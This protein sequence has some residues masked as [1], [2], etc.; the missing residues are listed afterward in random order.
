MESKILQRMLSITIGC[1]LLLSLLP[2]ANKINN[3]ASAASTRLGLHV[4]QEEIEIWRER[5]EIGPYREINDAGRN[6]RGEWLRI[7]NNAQ[8]FLNNPSAERWIPKILEGTTCPTPENMG[9]NPDRR[10]GDKIRDA[11]F[12]YLLFGG[13]KYLTAVRNELIAQVSEPTTDFS[14]MLCELSMWQN[15]HDH[16]SRMLK[17][18]FA[19]DYVRNDLSEQ[20]R[21][22]LDKWF[23]EA[24]IFY[25]ELIDAALG[26][27]F[28]DRFGPDKK[29]TQSAISNQVGAGRYAYYGGPEM[30]SVGLNHNNRATV[31][32]AFVGSVG[33]MLDN[34]TLKR[35]SKEFVKEFIEH[36]IYADGTLTDFIRVTTTNEEQG[37]SYSVHQGDGVIMIA[38]AFARAGDTSLYE[39]KATGGHHEAYGENKD[40]LLMMKGSVSYIDGTFERYGTS[41]PKE[42][43]NPEFLINGWK[44]APGG[45]VG[46]YVYDV[47]WAQANVYYQDQQVRDAYTRESV[48]WEYPSSPL[49]GGANS[50]GGVSG[51]YPSKLFMFGQMEGKVW[52]YPGVAPV[53]KI[54]HTE[55]IGLTIKKK[56]YKS[57]ALFIGESKAMVYNKG[58]MIDDSNKEVTPIVK[59]GRTLVPVRFIAES[60][61]AEVDWN[62]ATS[63][64][65]VVLDGTTIELVLGQKTIKVNGKESVLD[66]PALTENGRTLLPL[67]AMVEAIGKNVFWDERGLIVIS[68]NKSLFDTNDKSDA[69]VIEEIISSVWG[70]KVEKKEDGTFEKSTIDIPVNEAGKVD[71]GSVQIVK[72]VASGDDGNV[73]ENII[74]NDL[75]TR[76]SANGVEEWIRFDLGKVVDI[77]Y[78][79]IAFYNG[80][81]RKTIFEIQYSLDGEKWEDVFSGEG[82]GTSLDYEQFNVPGKARYIRYNGKGS[83]VN[84][85][86]SVTE[87]KVYEKK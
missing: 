5:A 31:A 14:K 56:L 36:A 54:K 8:S 22:V 29:A 62:E 2:F 20:D 55:S 66:V 28:T 41:D 86:N 59:D 40:L 30:H 57:I 63:T 60:V 50:W 32:M 34:E 16:S 72:V 81:T 87:F 39:Y 80:T 3:T 65:K 15:Q 24:A 4:T 74:D 70:I 84:T 21:A 78:L 76:W 19:Y 49:S 25:Q 37:W 69:S 26:K 82:S 51:V 53:S 6:N 77:D 38:D 35:S 43:G 85:W 48:S 79:K 64:I 45:S 9:G 13:E 10:Q 42:V 71:D 58:K 75:E 61:G 46:G 83:S 7:D 11:A 44:L 52:P 47:S 68:D 67:R 1:M 23:L 27:A 12:Y 18:L 17:Q 33:I 73:P